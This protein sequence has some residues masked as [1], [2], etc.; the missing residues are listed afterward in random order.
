MPRFEYGDFYK[1]CVSLGIALI[2]AAVLLPWLFLREPFDLML[3]ASK[4]ALLTP[5]AQRVVIARQQ[6]LVGLLPKIPWISVALLVLGIAG[7]ISGLALWYRRQILRNKSEELTVRK[8]EKELS[9]M[10][11]EEITKKAVADIEPMVSSGTLSLVTDVAAIKF[12]AVEQEF[13]GRV[14]ECIQDSYG[15]LNNQRLGS[16]EYD[17]ILQSL[18]SSEPDGIIEIKYITKGFKHSWLRESAMRLS[19]A[20]ELYETRLGRRSRPL[21][22]VIFS[23]D[24][25][26]E[27]SEFRSLKETVMADLALRS[28]PIRIEVLSEK[29]VSQLPCDQLRRLVFP[30][31]Q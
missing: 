2:A 14:R 8:K 25:L 16:A 17:V 21:L 24:D 7:A 27:R 19:L 28:T 30:I 1:F 3:E 13:Q 23:T 12:V 6:I 26:R 11:A 31:H 29:E 9:S 20:T 4:L 22:L 18:R 5:T 10:S 15:I